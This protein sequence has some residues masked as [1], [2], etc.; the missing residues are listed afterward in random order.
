MKIERVRLFLK[1]ELNDG[2]K[3]SGKILWAMKKS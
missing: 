2:L 3:N 1:P